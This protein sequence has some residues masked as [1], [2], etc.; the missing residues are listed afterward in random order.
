[1]TPEPADRVIAVILAAGLGTRMLGPNKLLE[2]LDGRPIVRHVADAA[3]AS[4]AARVVVVLGHEANRVREALRELDVD[5][6]DNPG[7]LEGMASSIRSAVTSHG[8]LASAMVFCLADM[9]RVS[10]EV[11]DALIAAHQGRPQALACQPMHG[12]R[13]GNPVLWTRAAFPALS[14]LTGGEG[15]RE[16]LAKHRDRVERV[17]VDCP[18]I[19]LDIDTAADLAALRSEPRG[20]A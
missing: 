19:L 18:G 17:E 15:A 4:R 3:L 13:R 6:V 11:I 5:F 14:V 8:V 7:F 20:P 12:G 10:T 2:A 16:L 1:M 9:P